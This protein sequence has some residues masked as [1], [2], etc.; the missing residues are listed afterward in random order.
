MMQEEPPVV[1]DGYVFGFRTLRYSRQ[2]RD[3][4]RRKSGSLTKLWGLVTFQLCH[5]VNY[6]RDRGQHL[7]WRRRGN[8]KALPVGADIITVEKRLRIR[9]KESAGNIHC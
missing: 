6:Y 3:Q 4:W 2:K 8:E 7:P 5:P 1:G 9:L